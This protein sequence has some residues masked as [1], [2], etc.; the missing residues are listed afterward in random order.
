MNR[1]KYNEW[2]A[3]LN[4]LRVRMSDA[5]V[6]YWQGVMQ[7]EADV[8]AWEKKGGTGYSTFEEVLHVAGLKSLHEYRKFKQCV[9][10]LGSVDAVREI[11]FAA[12]KELRN[13]PDYVPSKIEPAKPAVQAAYG[14]LVDF[15][16]I[17]GKEPSAQTAAARVR[18]HYEP[19]R[20]PRKKSR[21]DELKEENS[22]LRCENRAL[23]ARVK[24]L[25]A[26][27]EN[28]LAGEFD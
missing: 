10:K 18:I 22:R 3:Y 8:E 21:F 15:R 17:R 20:Q 11:G 27:L 5:E 14:E 19:L 9:E 25:E 23:K 1:T 4:D 12:A 24:Q 13:V 28:L 26:E 2:I 16:R 7:F 6:D